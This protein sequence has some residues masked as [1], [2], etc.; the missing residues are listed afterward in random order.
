MQRAGNG[1]RRHGE[2]VHIPLVIFDLFLMFH[3]ET[4]FFVENKQ[5]QIAEFHVG[6][7]Q[8]VRADNEVDVP[9]REF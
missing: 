3:A 9:L 2:A 7:E 1:R 8:A 6:G 4:L 5:P